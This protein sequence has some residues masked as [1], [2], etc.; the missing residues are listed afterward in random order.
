MFW[1]RKKK[2]TG[3]SEGANQPDLWTALSQSAQLDEIAKQSETRPQLIFKHSTRCGISAMVWRT[4]ERTWAEGEYAADLYVLDLLN[5]RS[6]SN[7]IAERFQVFHQS[8]QLLIIK[9]GTAV[10]HESHGAIQEVRL[11]DYID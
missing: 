5:Y 9:N 2:D 4:F 7:E 8:P 10:L 1:K 6:V 11:S 3:A